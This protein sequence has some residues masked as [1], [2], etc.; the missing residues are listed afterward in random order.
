[1]KRLITSAMLAALM[2]AGTGEAEAQFDGR[3]ASLFDL[4]VYAGGAWTSPWLTDIQPGDQQVRIGINPIFGATA[5]YW[6]APTWGLRLHGAYMPA[7]LYATGTQVAPGFPTG[8]PGFFAR[9]ERT[10]NNWF[11]DLNLVLRPW[12]ASDMG[13]FLASTYFFLGGGGLTANPAGNAVTCVGP[14]FHYGACLPY[15]WE[16]AT[17]GQ[18]TLGVGFDLLSLGASMG[19]FG[20][21]GAHIYSSPFHTGPGWTGPTA[22]GF[23]ANDPMAA[24]VRGVLGLKFLF[25]DILPPPPP[26]IAPPP[27][28]TPPPPPP[29][30]ERAITVCVIVDGQI[31][32]VQAVFRPDA[33]DTLVMVD[34]TRRPFRELH[35]VTAPNYAAGATW[36]VAAEPVTFGGR[37]YDRFGLP[38][39]ITPAELRRVGEFQG[40]PVFAAT[41]APAQP[42]VVYVPVR[43]GCEFQAYQLQEVTRRVRG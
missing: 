14:W 20:E 36:F 22:A 30:A 37:R 23:T 28:V 38:R 25:G 3:R 15:E 40:V 41:D 35:P 24:T 17:V 19:L 34:G 4:G 5:T 7:Q 1:M 11:Y 2:V 16:K 39:V 26:V 18:G 42:E 27:P 6:M 12:F 29:P 13:D 9:E 31:Q 32:Q 8:Q 43:T 33:G 10:I 21:I